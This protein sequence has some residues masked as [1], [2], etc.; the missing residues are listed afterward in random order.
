MAESETFVEK[1][2]SQLEDIIEDYPEI[3][4]SRAF[5]IWL[6]ESL[7]GLERDDAYEASEVGGPRDYGVDALVKIDSLHL[8]T[9]LQAKFSDVLS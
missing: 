7:E 4:R 1:V 3:D 2:V 5:V 6:L 8:V 9:I